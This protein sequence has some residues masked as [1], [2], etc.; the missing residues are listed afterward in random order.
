MLSHKLLAYAARHKSGESDDEHLSDV[1]DDIDFYL[2][3]D[4]KEVKAKEDIWMTMNSEFLEA[5]EDKAR[6]VCSASYLHLL[7]VLLLSLPCAAR[8][9]AVVDPSE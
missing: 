5:Q 2:I 8:V 7:H 9:L 4:S 6:R 3:K 1:D